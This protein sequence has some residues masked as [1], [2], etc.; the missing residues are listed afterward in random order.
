MIRISNISLPVNYSRE[1]LENK[2]ISILRA[3]K[4][5]IIKISLFRK[6]IDA[7]K[8][9]DIHFIVSADVEVAKGTRIVFGKNVTKAKPYEY[10]Y[11]RAGKNTGHTVVVGAGP[12]GLFAALTLARAGLKPI[13]IERGKSVDNRVCDVEHFWETGNLSTES[14]VQFG[15]GGAGTFSDG[16]LNTG[17][18]DIRSRQ[19]LREFASHGAP[20]EIL[21]D[22]KPHIGTD[23]LRETI[24]NIRNEIIRLGGRV[25]FSAKLT[26]IKI[27]AN[28]VSGICYESC[29]KSESIDCNSVI[30]AI[31]HS[32]RDTFEMI[33]K[34]GIPIEQKPFSLGARIEH[35]RLNIDKAQYGRLAGNK[36]LGASYYKLSVHL[37]NNRGVY[38]FCMC[39]GGKVVAAA[40]EQNR[41]VTNGMSNHSRNE[42]NSNSALLVGITPNDF[43]SE[44]KLAGMYLQQRLEAL[45]FSKGGGN[46]RAPVQRVG[47]F[48]NNVKSTEFGEVLPT[49]RPGTE[50]CKMDDVL[51]DFVC[52][53]MREALPML[54]NKLCGFSHNDALLTGIETRSSSPIRILRNESLEST[55]IA[56]L[57]PCGEG[58]GYA[59]GIVSAAVDGMKCAEKII[60]KTYT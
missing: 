26:E 59:G 54:N 17:T 40:S 34:A 39:P 7:R 47:D 16:K 24:K 43:K 60:D 20:E 32:S 31:G 41:L 3:K 19:I 21:Y 56:G 48:L 13:V 25:I 37:K 30:L 36:N 14:N 29:G 52:E 8:S 18:K 11:K 46:Y 53:S 27:N 58:A 45:A 44:H 42:I 23:K 38:T 49:Y 55:K 12:A 6:S 57:Y 9:N 50:F 33:Y 10:T 5:D 35:L 51:P 4:S 1:D 2:V 22:A 28:R 15:E